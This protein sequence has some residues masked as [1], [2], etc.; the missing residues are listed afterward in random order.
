MN[1]KVI[2]LI[3]AILALAGCGNMVHEFHGKG[4]GGKSSPG[5]PETAN[6]RLSLSGGFATKT[7]GY[8]VSAFGPGEYVTLAVSN[9]GTEQSAPLIGIELVNTDDFTVTPVDAGALGALV[10]GLAPGG[11]AHYAIKPKNGCWPGT[12]RAERVTV[13]GTGQSAALGDFEVKAHGYLNLTTGQWEDTDKNPAGSPLPGC[14][15]PNPFV[16][17]SGR[18]IRVYG[19]TTNPNNRIEVENGSPVWIGL[20]GASIDISGGGSALLL[21]MGAELML[22]LGAAGVVNALKTGETNKAGLEAPAGTW[23]EITG[24]G[25]LE[26]ANTNGSGR[27]A[28]IGGGNYETG[29]NITISG[30]TVAALGGFDGGAGIGGGYSGNGGSIEITGDGTVIAQGG[31]DNSSV[32]GAGIGGGYYGNGG[33]IAIRGGRITA[34]GGMGGGGGSSNGE[35]GAGIGGGGSAAD[36]GNGG[37]IA[38]TG[39]TIIALG[40]SD[41]YGGAGIGGGGNYYTH[42]GGSGGNITILGGTVYSAPGNGWDPS[43]IGHGGGGNETTVF[44]TDKPVIFASSIYNS[45][46]SQSSPANGIAGDGDVTVIMGT[47]SVIVGGISFDTVTSV[48]VALADSFIVPSGVT[49]TIPPIVTLNLNGQTLTNNGTI[50]VQSGGTLTGA[51]A[52]PGTVIRE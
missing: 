35:S 8:N 3:V 26:A 17:G 10:A 12:Y 42:N 36:S 22:N 32:G 13:S 34:L 6:I 14:L 11:S 47:G 48:N 45:S 23:L 46:S 41:D 2:L 1:K 51:P 24:N 4:G 7:Y 38:I 16:I 39:G 43:G 37:S 18:A 27:G 49:L 21:Q 30:G 50:V 44:N 40:G 33:S 9:G 52:G 29:G 19:N 28:G 15:G 25:T 5:N 31:G 20:D